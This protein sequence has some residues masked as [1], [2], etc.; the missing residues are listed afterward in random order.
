MAFLEHDIHIYP[1]YYCI[2]SIF[3]EILL[4]GLLENNEFVNWKWENENWSAESVNNAQTHPNIVAYFDINRNASEN[5]V[6]IAI[7]L[8]WNSQQQ[9]KLCTIP[10][11]LLFTNLNITIS[12]VHPLSQA[13]SICS[14]RVLYS[15]FFFLFFFLNVICSFWMTLTHLSFIPVVGCEEHNENGISFEN[16]KKKTHILRRTNINVFVIQIRIIIYGF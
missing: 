6:F 2:P 8:H 11:A 3:N 1:L 9:Q 14:A 15:A 13:L 5:V 12:I 10:C 4:R 16:G 7:S